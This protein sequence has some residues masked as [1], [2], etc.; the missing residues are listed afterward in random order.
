MNLTHIATVRHCHRYTHLHTSVTICHEAPYWYLSCDTNAIGEADLPL[1]F[2]SRWMSN[3]HLR[4]ALTNLINK[5]ILINNCGC[6]L[7]QACASWYRYTPSVRA[8][9]K[10]LIKE[11]IDWNPDDSE[12]GPGSDGK[13][14]SKTPGKHQHN[15]LEA[16][17]KHIPHLEST[18]LITKQLDTMV[19]Q[20]NAQIEKKFCRCLKMKHTLGSGDNIPGILE[21]NPRLVDYTL[22]YFCQTCRDKTTKS[23][24]GK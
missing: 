15:A 21:F 17:L 2:S 6:S 22:G 12:V 9:A 19:R 7:C 20:M 1:I 10:K 18:T 5:K 4:A 8:I 24:G 16:G 14:I 11:L 13:R 3:Y 23:K